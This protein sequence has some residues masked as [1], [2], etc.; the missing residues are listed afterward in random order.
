MRILCLILASDTAPEYVKFQ[1]LWR[2]FMNLNPH[3]DCYFYKAHPDLSQPTFLADQTLWIRMNDKFETVYEKTLQAFDYFIPELDKYDFVYRSNLSTFV[4]FRHMLE[5]CA[6][7]PKT[8]CCA[9][10]TGGIEV[11]VPQNERNSLAH[12]YSFPGGNGF[13]VSPDIMKRIVEERIPLLVQDDVTIGVALRKWGIPI[14]EFVRP[15]YGN[16]GIW[17]VN[18][19]DLLQSH[20]R[21][22]DPK[23]IMFTYRIK[24]NDRT[25]DLEIMDMLIRKY[26][27]V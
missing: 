12:P 13:I 16:M 24:S 1:A 23:K 11:N 21:N 2:R 10:V 9:G 22:L 5:F 19:Y 17:Y 8:G 27:N 14:R 20:E 18:N 25:K 3:V 6:D 26:C 15:D 4:S 7:L